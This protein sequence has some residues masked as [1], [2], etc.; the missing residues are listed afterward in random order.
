VTTLGHDAGAFTDGSN[1]PDQAQFKQLIVN[2]ILSSMGKKPFCTWSA[3][4]ER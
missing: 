4:S 2:G 3:E 1:F